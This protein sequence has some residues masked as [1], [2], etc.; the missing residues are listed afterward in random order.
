MHRLNG[1]TLWQIILAAL[2]VFI[3]EVIASV[4]FGPSPWEQLT[5]SRQSSLV[6]L[7]W[8]GLGGIPAMIAT[9]EKFASEDPTFLYK[10]SGFI[11]VWAS[12]WGLWHV[13]KAETLRVGPEIVGLLFVIGL[14]AAVLAVINCGFAWIA[15]WIHGSM[16]PQLKKLWSL[17]GSSAMNGNGTPLS[18][19]DSATDSGTSLEGIQ[20]LDEPRQ[21]RIRTLAQIVGYKGQFHC[22][23]CG[24]PAVPAGTPEEQCPRCETDSFLLP[25]PKEKDCTCGQKV[26]EGNDY[27]FYCGS[28]LDDLNNDHIGI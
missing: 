13:L 7:L 3:V 4:L 18:S 22:S 10:V 11:G 1:P 26:G 6:S 19:L 9:K 16:V 15:G 25:P 2:A 14:A 24:T 23:E 17:T 28:P 5:Q 8:M 12:V 27:C 20:E 21:S